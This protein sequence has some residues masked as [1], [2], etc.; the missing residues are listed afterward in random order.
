M[1]EAGGVWMGQ[2]I[3]R[4]RFLFGQRGVETVARQRHLQLRLLRGSTF[5]PDV[6][7]EWLEKSR[8][9][10]AAAAACPGVG[11]SWSRSDRLPCESG[12]WRPRRHND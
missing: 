1:G 4:F 12:N 9:H 3:H 6:L 2:A 7:P 11:Q 10:A 5:L 8:P